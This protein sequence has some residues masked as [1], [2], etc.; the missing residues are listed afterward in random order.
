M[1]H[2]YPLR[3]S[4]ST[5]YCFCMTTSTITRSQLRSANATG[6]RACRYGVPR[7]RA[8][9]GYSDPTG[10]LHAAFL[11]GHDRAARLGSDWH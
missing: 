9:L 6:E 2:G 1:D 10:E 4:W 7:E 5:R 3:G 8:T 11:R